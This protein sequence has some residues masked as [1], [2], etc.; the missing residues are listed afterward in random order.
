MGKSLDFVRNRI[1]SGVCNGMEN[2]KYELMQEID[3]IKALQYYPHLL[4]SDEKKICE[5]TLSDVTMINTDLKGDIKIW[6]KYDP[7]AEFEYFTMERCKTD[8][9]LSFFSD[10]LVRVINKV[11]LFQ[12][13]NNVKVPN[14]YDRN[15]FFYTVKYV[16]GNPVITIEHGDDFATEEKPWLL[17]RFS[18][19]LPI[20]MDFERI[21]IN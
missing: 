19:M 7:Y 1:A 16:I 12:T 5:Y 9:T 8:G 18:I 14:D 4:F 21:N 6:V 3:L 11:F 2:N 10:L 20:A 13:Y 15:P 17:D